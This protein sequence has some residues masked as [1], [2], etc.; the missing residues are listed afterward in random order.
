MRP[1]PQRCLLRDGREGNEKIRGG[2][3]TE[4]AS[5]LPIKGLRQSLEVDEPR[6]VLALGRYTV[7]QRNLEFLEALLIIRFGSVRLAAPGLRAPIFE[8]L[9]IFG[10]HTV[11]YL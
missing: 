3:W 11:Q 1:L 5:V 4:T 10:T 2:L 6:S 7:K 9:Y 8:K